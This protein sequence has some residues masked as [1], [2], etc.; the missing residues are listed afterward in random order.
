MKC[1]VFYKMQ[2]LHS[3]YGDLISGHVT[4]NSA[5]P[6]TMRQKNVIVVLRFHRVLGGGSKILLPRRGCC[7]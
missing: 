2:A 6:F 1:D 4:T 5:G 3:S 7:L